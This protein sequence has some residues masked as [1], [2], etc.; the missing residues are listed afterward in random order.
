MG[1]EGGDYPILDTGHTHAS[2]ICMRDRPVRQWYQRGFIAW[3]LA[4]LI[5]IVPLLIGGKSAADY[6]PSLES[7]L[8]HRNVQRIERQGVH[9][10]FVGSDSTANTIG[11]LRCMRFRIFRSAIDKQ[12]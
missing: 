12:P 5:T 11:E 9:I 1:L 8:V 7:N 6:F 4:V 10:K 2:K 3:L